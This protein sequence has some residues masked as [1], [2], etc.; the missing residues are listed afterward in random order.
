MEDKEYTSNLKKI[1]L[2]LA[3]DGLVEITFRK[4][5]GTVREMK[6]TLNKE[7]I[8]QELGPQE[9]TSAKQRKENPDVQKVFDWDKKA[10]RSFRWDS[11]V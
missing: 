1:F 7:L 6:C 10:W 8:E 11:L 5:D 4:A 9:Q 2:E 3:Y